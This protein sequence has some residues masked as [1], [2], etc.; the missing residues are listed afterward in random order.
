VCVCIVSNKG[1]MD[2]CM[3]DMLTPGSCKAKI[4]SASDSGSR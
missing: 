3:W 1:W 4:P 2:V